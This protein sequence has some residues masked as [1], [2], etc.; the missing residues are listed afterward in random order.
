MPTGSITV[1]PV[2]EGTRTAQKPFY[3]F[4]A[5]ST[6]ATM[7][8]TFGVYLIEDLGVP[9]AVARRR[10]SGSLSDGIVYV[11]RWLTMRDLSAATDHRFSDGDY[12]ALGAEQRPASRL[13]DATS[14]A[15]CQRSEYATTRSPPARTH[16]YRRIDKRLRGT[17]RIYCRC[18]H[19]LWG[20]KGKTDRPWRTVQ[21]LRH[22]D[23]RRRCE[24]MNIEAV[25]GMSTN[26]DSG[27]KKTLQQEVDDDR[28]GWT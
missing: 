5:A 15:S 26:S 23:S 13:R 12:D 25:Q 6:T 1:D 22:R 7:D 27:D 14:M 10:S 17:W 21:N 2:R 11:E 28:Q 16:L 3:S 19:G 9:L 24:A 8:G 4:S 20:C 18:T